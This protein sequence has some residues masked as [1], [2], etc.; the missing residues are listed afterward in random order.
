MDAVDR[1]VEEVIA[2]A[3]RFGASSAYPDPATLHLHVLAPAVPAVPAPAGAATVQQGWLEAVRD[4]IAEEFRRDPAS[5][6][7]GEGIGERGGSFGQSKGLWKEF[8]GAR[9]VDTAI[10]ELAFTGAAAGAA[11]T[12]T[13]AIADLMFADFL[14]EA[15]S[16]IIH[17][18]AKLRYLTNGRIGGSA[19]IRAFHGMIKSAGAHHSGSY[20]TLWG[21]VPGLI[22]A[23]PSNPADAKGMIKS[24]LR[25]GDPVV[26]LEHKSLI[27]TK[28]LV[29]VGDYTV[30]LGVAAV[31]RPGTQ[32]TIA[33]LGLLVG[34]SLEAAT[35]LE[36][37]GISV[38]V[39]DLR[40]I[41]PLD[42][43][44]VAA[45]VRR[46]SRL[47]V[48]DEAW[49]LYGV[50]GEVAQAVQE[51]AFDYLDAPI[52][53]LHT[54]AVPFPFS[55]TLDSI[56]GVS[57]EQIVA[58][59]RR[60]FAGES[61]VSSAPTAS[62]APA[63]AATQVAVPAAPGAAPQPAQQVVAVAPA[64]VPVAAPAPAPVADNPVPAGGVAIRIPNMDLTIT[65]AKV[66]YWLKKTG[67]PITLGEPVAEVETDKSLVQIESPAAGR[68]AQI[69]AQVGTVLP[70]GATIGYIAQ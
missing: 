21:H 68:L 29:P 17:Q 19:V 34:K 20:Y 2:E 45:S 39:I 22:V 63:L 54:Q 28:G 33:T 5:I 6:Y 1:E 30:P 46:T 65:E 62:P 7:L 35:K 25:S 50:G 44:T 36:Q 16:Q 24:A 67:D 70:L 52:G 10:S 56:V 11:A 53:R 60:V 14:F 48:V 69:T 31:V 18:A 42:V 57:V 51:R 4:G 15:G 61:L 23:V 41:A 9:I 43:E 58:A 38:E 3:Q 26:F 32:L 66:V 27:S 12:G 64:P 13:R 55:P 37:L 59:A 40:T 47:L 8:G 49:S